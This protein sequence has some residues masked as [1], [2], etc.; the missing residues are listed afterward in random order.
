MITVN[1]NHKVQPSATPNGVYV[2]KSVEQGR[3]RVLPVSITFYYDV[4]DGKFTALDVISG[5]FQFD[6]F[7]H[8]TLD[9]FRTPHEA[10]AFTLSQ[11]LAAVNWYVD[12]RPSYNRR[13]DVEGIGF[14]MDFDMTLTGMPKHENLYFHDAYAS[15]AEKRISEY[16][17]CVLETVGKASLDHVRISLSPCCMLYG[18]EPADLKRA[19][20]FINLMIDMKGIP[21]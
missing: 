10:Y 5:H 14:G 3:S 6:V 17:G 9:A 20:D 21:F 7:M 18:Y 16:D 11:T 4:Q 8:H 15:H 19:N 12:N 2:L 1:Y 13:Y